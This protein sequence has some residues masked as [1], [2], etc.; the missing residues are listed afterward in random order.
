LKKDIVNGIFAVTYFYKKANE[1]EKKDEEDDDKIKYLPL[2]FLID[3]ENEKIL[4]ESIP[5]FS[6]EK[7][8]NFIINSF[9]I[10]FRS[11]VHLYKR[12]SSES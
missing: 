7:V 10:K 4:T 11:T 5:D 9:F 1:R 12:G 3:S 8:N 6:F 2:N